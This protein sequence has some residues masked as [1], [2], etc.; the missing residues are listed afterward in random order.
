MRRWPGSVVGAG[1]AVLLAVGFGACGGGGK[2]GSG[3]GP[4]GGPSDGSQLDGAGSSSGGF[5]GDDSGGGPGQST[6]V[7]GCPMGL[8][9]NDGICDP[10]QPMC[11]DNSSCEDD[12]YCLSGVC[13]PYGGNHVSDPMCQQVSPAGIFAPVVLCEFTSAPTGDPFPT[14]LDVQAT[15]TV[16]NFDLKKLGNASIPSIVAPFEATV[17]NSD[18]STGY[19]ENRGILRILKGSD[20]SLQANLAGVDLDGDGVVDWVNSPSAVA[21]ADLNGDGVAELVTYM[22][23][24]TMVAFTRTS[25]GKWTTL[26]PKVKATDTSGAVL[27]FTGDGTGGGKPNPAPAGTSVWSGP[28]IHD[29]DNDGKPEIIREGYVVDGQTG[30]LRASPPTGYASYQRRHPACPGGP[31]Q[32]R[33]RRAGR[34]APTSGSSTARRAR[35]PRSCRTRPARRPRPGG[36]GSPTSTRT[37]ARR[38]P[39]SPSSRAATCRSTRSTTRCS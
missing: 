27:V 9:C 31:L 15:P 37:T 12:E 36:W 8:V 30:V 16:V 4:D 34:R 11:V 3:F 19:T 21:A 25:S 10:V 39:R 7:A 1:T 17:V 6:C 22:G 5:G 32:R 2:D 28:S 14:L 33:Q 24:F 29:L 23:D 26:W 18:G 38:R 13:V 35:G 20:C